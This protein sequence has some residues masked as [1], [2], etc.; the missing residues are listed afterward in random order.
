MLNAHPEIVSPPECGFVHWWYSKYKGW[1]WN[2]HEQDLE[3]FITD[4]E[5]SKKIETWNLDFCQLHEFI[6]TRCPNSY[7]ELTTCVYF[8]Y[9][10]A[11]RKKPLVIADKNNYYINHLKELKEIWSDA[12]FI[13]LIR[14][15]RDVACSYIDLKTMASDSKYKPNLSNKINE[16]ANEWST[17]N[18]NIGDFIDSLSPQSGKSIRFE[19]LILKTEE[20]LTEISEFLQ[21]TFCKEMLNYNDSNHHNEPQQTM[22]WKRK[23]LESPDP[24]RISRFKSQLKQEEIEVFNSIANKTLLRYNYSL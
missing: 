6:K 23:T 14:D 13:H 3:S 20:T 12:L 18:Q 4:L 1:R 10:M 7:D 16:I 22:D 9:A 5:S 8:F 24:E 11:N 17:N 21:V 15:G 2:S 19:D